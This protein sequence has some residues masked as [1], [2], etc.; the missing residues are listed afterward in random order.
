MDILNQFG[1]NPI[2]LAAQVV[3][4]LILLWI[5]NKFLYKP[6]IK[7]LEARKK[8]ISQSLTNVEEIEKKLLQTEED[9]EKILAEA[10]S[11]A[12][13][14][15][16][17]TKKELVLLREEEKQKII[18]ETEMMIKKAKE[19]AQM[20]RAK[21]LQ[22]ARME[23]MSLVTTVLNKVTGKVIVGKDQ[24]EMIEKEIKNLS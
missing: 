22:Q 19:S 12:Q 9:R 6:V 5:L 21:A 24:K 2:L 10:S 18:E 16:D 14:L 3:N 7:V 11:E 1:I 8:K 4:F 23:I 13:K 20:E 17:E 15:V